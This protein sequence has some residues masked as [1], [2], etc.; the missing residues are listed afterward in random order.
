M[1]HSDDYVQII[2]YREEEDF[3]LFR[4]LHKMNMRL[5]SIKDS[6][7]KTSCQQLFME[8]V[9]LMSFNGE[10][11]YPQIKKSKEINLNLPCT[12]YK[13][14][15]QAAISRV[16]ECVRV[17]CNLSFAYFFERLHVYVVAEAYS[18]LEGMSNSLR[19]TNKQ[20]FEM[21]IEIFG[22]PDQ[23]PLFSLLCK[24]DVNNYRLYFYNE[25][26]NEILE[27]LFIIGKENHSEVDEGI[28]AVH[29][30]QYDNILQSPR[31]MYDQKN[32]SIRGIRQ[33]LNLTYEYVQSFWKKHPAFRFV[34][35]TKQLYLSDWLKCMTY[36]RGFIEAYTQTSRTNTTLRISRFNCK[37]VVKTRISLEDIMKTDNLSIKEK[38]GCVTMNEYFYSINE[39]LARMVKPQQNPLL[40][41]IIMRC[42]TTCSLVYDVLKN[43]NLFY[44]DMGYQKK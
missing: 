43:S 21:P 34:K 31:F 39:K 23:F 26:S 8:F 2:L 40:L 29:E 20:R 11:L 16:G 3:N 14:D 24:G 13:S 38:D 22:F 17:G 1:E 4:A 35:P 33:K 37:R 28:V 41:R 5:H 36:N 10:M 27:K 6:D 19:I 12:G 25:Y 9:S 30:D 44:K 18:L 42:D 32:N 7:R 15:M